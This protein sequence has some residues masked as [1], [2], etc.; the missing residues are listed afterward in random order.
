MGNGCMTFI[1][2]GVAVVHTAITEG[3]WVAYRY[4]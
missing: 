2:E 1:A 4:C 3:V